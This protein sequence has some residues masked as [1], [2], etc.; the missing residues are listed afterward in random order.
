MY[1]SVSTR[2]SLIAA[3]LLG[4]LMG[5]LVLLFINM[6]V[7]WILTALL[8]IGFVT[9]VM[10]ID[11][12]ERFFWVLFIMSLQVYVSLWFFHGRA[13]SGGL[14]FPLAFVSGVMLLSY[15]FLSGYFPKKKIFLIGGDLAIPISLVFASTIFSLLFSSERFVGLVSLW[16]LVQYYVFYLIGLNCVQSKK[17]LTKYCHY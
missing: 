12:R 17:H 13:G 4:A 10:A 9:L 8:A 3:I 15:Y 5:L 2:F 11:D 16:T 1:K 7:K 14:E 6:E